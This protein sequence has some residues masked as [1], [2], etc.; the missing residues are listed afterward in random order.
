MVLLGD[1][2]RAHLPRDRFTARARYQVPVPL[3]L[4]STE[5]RA[6]TVWRA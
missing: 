6:A 4:E 1:P 3:T 5:T 2:D